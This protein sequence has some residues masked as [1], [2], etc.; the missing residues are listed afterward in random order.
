LQAIHDQ[1]LAN[2]GT[3]ITVSPEYAE[4]S[5]DVSEKLGLT[6]PVLEDTNS[7][8]AEEYGLQFE[9]PGDLRELYRQFGNDLEHFNTHGRW[10]LPLPATFVV[11]RE[12]IVRYRAVNAD[13][14]HR[15]EPQAALDIMAGH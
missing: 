12:G 15:P 11:D 7:R 3:L 13:Y 9:L 14:T 10:E 2:G 6:F 8:V 4:F 5:K 1:I